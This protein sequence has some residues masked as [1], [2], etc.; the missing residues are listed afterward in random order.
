MLKTT[1]L[2]A[3]EWCLLQAL[4]SGASNKELALVLSRSEFTIRNQL[5]SL[6]RKINVSNRVHAIFWYREHAE[7]FVPVRA[8]PL[9]GS[10]H[11]N[12]G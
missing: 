2:N 7:S 5:S 6:Y 3:N 8:A 4:N 12:P 11:I 1:E 9:E 10:S